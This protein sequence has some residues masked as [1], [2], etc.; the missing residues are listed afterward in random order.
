[1]RLC[2]LFWIAA[3][4]LSLQYVRTLADPPPPGPTND[5]VLLP[6]QPFDTDVKMPNNTRERKGQWSISGGVYVI[7]PVFESNPAF[8]VSGAAGNVTRQVEFDHNLDVA[9]GAWLGYVSERGWGVRGR[10]FQF[11]HGAGAGYTAAPGETITGLSPLPLGRTPINGAIAASSDLAVNVADLQGT[12]SYEDAKWTLLAGF[13]V[14]YT[15][16]SQDYRAALTNPATRIELTSGHNLN[17]WGPDFSLETKRQIGESGFAVYGQM[18]GAI[19]F[20]RARE[21]YTAVNNG[22]LQQ[23]TRSYTDVLPV[24]ELEVGAEYQK[25]VGRAKVFLQAG[26]NGQIWFN[27]G[28]ASNIDPIGFGSASNSNF[29][30]VGLAVRAGVRY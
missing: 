20:G 12:C 30:F 17:G 1:M 29:G 25:N 19:L 10:W 3:L 16:M 6:P 26:F 15:H 13:G 23:F 9:P 2:L 18:H 8:L 14:R 7:Q 11:D 5:S 22:V 28:N 27:G 4:A 24:G 21:A